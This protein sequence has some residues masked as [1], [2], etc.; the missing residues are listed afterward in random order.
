MRWD[1]VSALEWQGEYRIGNFWTICR[2]WGN[3]SDPD[4]FHWEFRLPKSP[5]FNGDRT[6]SDPIESGN[7]QTLPGAKRAAVRASHKFMVKTGWTA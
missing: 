4:A 7:L 1:N 3:V 5:R 6:E 2:V